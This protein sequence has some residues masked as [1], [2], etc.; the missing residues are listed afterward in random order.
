MQRALV[1]VASASAL[2]R[3]LVGRTIARWLVGRDPVARATADF[4]LLTL[5]RNR[6]Q[7]A[8]IATAAAIGLAVIVAGL[9]G[10]SGDLQWMTRPT[11]DV[12]S[13]P[14]LVAFWIAVG[15]RASF[16]VPSELPS[17]WSFRSHA[18]E[19]ARSYW[20]ATRAVM[21]AFV[22][23]PML[24]VTALLSALVGWRIAA[25]H[26]L[27]GVA[28]TLL[29]VQLL[30]LTFAHV[31]YTRPYE[32]GHTKLRTRWPLYFFGMSAFAYWSTR[33]EWLLLTS[34][35]GSLSPLATVAA[36][37]LVALGGLE[38]IG[39]WKGAQWAIEEPEQS[40]DDSVRLSVLDLGPTPASA[41]LFS[42]GPSA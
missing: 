28:M 21:I 8:P 27:F 35:S 40:V 1:P 6:A 14:L 4:V 12:L 9:A 19:A 24:V 33:G 41:H 3:A 13:I 30:T 42:N 39:R 7:Q 20:S 32:P 23:P 16:F 34:T 38:A 36:F 37:F 11:A 2:G 5:A 10:R 15:L 26:A 29:L 17:G 25:W 18:P 22:L 31:P